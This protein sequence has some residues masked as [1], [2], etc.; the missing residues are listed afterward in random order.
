VIAISGIAFGA[1]VIYAVS[2]TAP[3]GGV[4]VD[5]RLPELSALAQRGSRLFRSNC[6]GCHGSNAG[7]SSTGPPP[8]HRIYEP[9]HHDD[10]A[11]RRAVRLGV[12]PHHWRFGPMPNVDVSARELDGIIEFVRELQRANGIR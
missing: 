1:A 5:V 2:G 3:Q 11:I 4:T 8:V 6:A 7:G 10:G 9:S 12:R